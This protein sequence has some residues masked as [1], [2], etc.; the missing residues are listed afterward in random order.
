MT[1][2][3]K[4]RITVCS[5]TFYIKENVDDV[6]ALDEKSTILEIIPYSQ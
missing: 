2:Y 5:W 3:S 4:Y 1:N 6:S